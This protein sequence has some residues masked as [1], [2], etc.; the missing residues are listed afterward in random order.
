MSCVQQPIVCWV[1]LTDY[2]HNNESVDLNN[3]LNFLN[4]RAAI[5]LSKR[6]GIHLSGTVKPYHKDQPHQPS[7]IFNICEID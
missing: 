6:A 2:E 4:S 1:N 5:S 7:R 3:K